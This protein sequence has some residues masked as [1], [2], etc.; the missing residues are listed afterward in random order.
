MIFLTKY[1]LKN[2]WSTLGAK[3]NYL[4]FKSIAGAESKILTISFEPLDTANVRG[5]NPSMPYK[6][7]NNKE[8]KTIQTPTF[9]FGSVR[10]W[11]SSNVTISA[12]SISTAWVN[13]VWLVISLD[14]YHR[15]I[16]KKNVDYKQTTHSWVWIYTFW[17]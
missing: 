10:G 15:N 2:K 6:E 1:A 16:I 9:R 11:E 7:M 13:G 4:R 12:L 5:V 14:H 3:I 8:W 17:I